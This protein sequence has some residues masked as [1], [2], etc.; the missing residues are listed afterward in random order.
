MPVKNTIC[1]RCGTR[2]VDASEINGQPSL[3]GVALVAPKAGHSEECYSD[4]RAEGA[5]NVQKHRDLCAACS[6]LHEDF[7]A[8]RAVPERG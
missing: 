5:C 7:Y 6:L 8:G 2:I 1:D 3:D 4:V